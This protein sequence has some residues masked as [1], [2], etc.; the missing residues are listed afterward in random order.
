MS[1]YNL[2]TIKKLFAM[3][4]N[5]CA[6]PGCHNPIIED[7][8]II[9]GEICHIKAK[10]PKGPRFDL[11]QTDKQRKSYENLILLCKRHHKIV[12]AEPDIYNVT[13]LIELKKHH[14]Q[15]YHKNESDVDFFYARMLMNDLERISIENNRGNIIIGSPNAIQGQTVVIKS[16]KEKVYINPPSGSIGTD[17]NLNGYIQYLIRRYNQFASSDTFINRKFNFGA[18]SKNIT[19]KFGCQW[20]LLPIANATEVM[21][22]LQARISRTRQAKIN[23]GKNKKAFSTFDEYRHKYR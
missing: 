9:T 11:K 5:V 6:F 20:R 3:S 10:N 23:K 1:E 19:D 4:G 2:A 13:A 12:D 14:E 21:E 16:S 7:S 8:T 15:K 18:I 17:I 22:Y